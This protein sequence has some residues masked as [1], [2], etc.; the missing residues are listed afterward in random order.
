MS[1]TCFVRKA[2]EGRVLDVGH[3]VGPLHQE[4]GKERDVV[5]IDTVIKRPGG[6]VVKADATH[7]PFKDRT[8]DSLLAGELIEHLERPELFLKE[9]RR[10]LRR[11]GVLVITTPNRKS[12]INRVFRSYEK[13]AHLSLFSKG[14]LFSLL[15]KYGFLVERWATFPYTEESSEGSSHKW[16]YPLRKLMHCFLPPGLREQMA[17]VARSI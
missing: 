2:L 12:L 14:E 3:S 6:R 11:K 17:V 8:F 4:I 9:G 15:G 5:G 1:R 16:F 7:M 13:P 10:V